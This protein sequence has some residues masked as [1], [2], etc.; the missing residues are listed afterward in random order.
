MHSVFSL[1]SP[2]SPINEYGDLHPENRSV[3]VNRQRKW[4]TFGPEINGDIGHVDR[5][6]EGAI[7]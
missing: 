1:L 2:L 5:A 4:D 7:D 3:T 6:P